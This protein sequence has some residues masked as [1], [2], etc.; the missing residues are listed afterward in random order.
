MVFNRLSRRAPLLFVWLLFLLTACGGSPTSDKQLLNR[1]CETTEHNVSAMNAYNLFWRELRDVAQE[2]DGVSLVTVSSS[3]DTIPEAQLRYEGRSPVTLVNIFAKTAENKSARD[4]Y[5][6]VIA[7]F[8]FVAEETNEFVPSE[9]VG[10]LA[11]QA[12]S[13]AGDH[14]YPQFLF[15]DDSAVVA[16]WEAQSSSG[17]FDSVIVMGA[18]SDWEVIPLMEES[19]VSLVIQLKEKRF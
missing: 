18:A 12:N 6:D 4:C 7:Q 15:S 5:S 16:T 19:Q 14:S 3:K 9:V 17:E 2:A 13:F 1:G 8:K 10:F 11:K